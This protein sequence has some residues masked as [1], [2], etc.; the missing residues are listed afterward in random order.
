[1]EYHLTII[2][3]GIQ[4]CNA[5]HDFVACM[6]FIEQFSVELFAFSPIAQIYFFIREVLLYFYLIV[7]IIKIEF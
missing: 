3:A 2:S 5:N 6:C 7:F 1:M 4:F